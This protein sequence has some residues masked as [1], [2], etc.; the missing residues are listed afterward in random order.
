MS[1]AILY[2]KLPAHGDF[3]TRGLSHAERDR[4]DLWLAASMADAGGRWGEAFA[5]RYDSAPPWRFVTGTDEGDCA[6]ALVPSMDGVGRRF[7]LLVGIIGA[8]AAGE[9]VAERCEDLLYLAIG[10]GW[11]ADRLAEAAAALPLDDEAPVAGDGVSAPRWWTLGG[12]DFDPAVLGRAWPE[13]LVAVMLAP[14]GD[15]A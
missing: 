6:G 10:E 2:G 1:R 14:A 15:G 3:V 5:N 11:D 13:E 9:R 12:D 4:L 7:P 8:G